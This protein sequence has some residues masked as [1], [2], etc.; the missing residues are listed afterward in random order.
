[1]KKLALVLSGGA[2]KGYAHIGVLK[3]LEQHNIKPS[4]IVGTSMGA[5]VGGMYASGKS[6][7]EL[8][9]IAYD[10]N[11]LGNFSLTGT[12][13]RG[14]LL[15]TRKVDKLL[16][17]ELGDLAQEQCKIPF[18]AVATELKT[19]KEAH[20]KKGCLRENIRASISIP[21]IFKVQEIN[22]KQYVD[23]GLCNNLPENVAHSIMPDAVIVSVDVIG[24]YAD[25]LEDL[26]LDTL[27][28]VLNA[29]T[30]LTQNVVRLRRRYAKIRIVI[31]QP[32]VSQLD[33][34][35]DKVNL[36]VNY[37]ETAANKWIEQ[38]ENLLK[39]D[40]YEN[41]EPNISKS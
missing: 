25:Q 35:Q 1:M 14:H 19:G 23:G 10:F 17:R 29:T 16:K 11:S 40:T 6:C 26:K 3:V 22:G 38:I 5:L 36:S 9:Q 15:D 24:K 7:E 20:L 28:N 37:G 33:F 12:L 8:V 13:F 39:G 31:S 32:D 4:L 41:F 27:E 2:A 34:K 21:G 18:V 30:I